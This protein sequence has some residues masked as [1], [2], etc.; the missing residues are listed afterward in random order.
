MDFTTLILVLTSFVGG[1]IAIPVGGTFLLVIPVM[2]MLG[3]NGLETIVLS[4]IFA[5][6]SLGGGSAYFFLKNRYEWK[7]IFYFLSG[8]FLGLMLAA[9]LANSIDLETLTAIIPWILL[10]GAVLLLKDIKIKNIKN[11]RKLYLLFP[12]VGLLFGFY[13]GL[14][15]S[16]TGPGVVI[17]LSLAL[18]WGMHKSIVN[19]RLMEFIGSSFMAISLLAF[20]AEFTGYEI[21]VVIA[22]VLGWLLWAKI[23]IK[24]NPVWIKRGLLILVLISAIKTSWP[25]I[26]SLL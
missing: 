1:I 3:F 14:G 17:L 15:G 12:F 10:A 11:Q 20:G 4:R 13:G 18:G 26:E 25:F 21:P 5:I 9:K 16:G 8:N 22:A 7:K 6:A 24:I 19:A 23:T 2:L